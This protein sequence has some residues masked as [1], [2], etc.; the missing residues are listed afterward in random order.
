M[1]INFDIIP[2]ILSTLPTP[3]DVIFCN[4]CFKCLLCFL[5]IYAHEMSLQQ[6]SNVDR[7]I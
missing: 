7:R 2:E 1:N 6:M 4:E 5:Q 3:S